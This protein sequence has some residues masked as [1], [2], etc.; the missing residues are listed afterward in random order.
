MRNPVHNI[1]EQYLLRC[2][3]RF[4][5]FTLWE[6]GFHVAGLWDFEY[7]SSILCCCSHK[8]SAASIPVFP[9]RTSNSVCTS[10]WVIW[11]GIVYAIV[12][13]ALYAWG[14]FLFTCLLTHFTRLCI[15]LPPLRLLLPPL[16]P[17]GLSSGGQTNQGR[18]L[19]VTFQQQSGD[20][21]SWLIQK[22][23][24]STEHKR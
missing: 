9:S 15:L 6:Q 20:D 21:L 2:L 17:L 16:L 12:V 11:C 8:G 7:S 18:Y 13:N 14:W 5:H 4:H 24:G 22:P 1:R 10:S 19:V 3:S 23:I